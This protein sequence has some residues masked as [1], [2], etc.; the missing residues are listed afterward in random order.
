MWRN[1][2][3]YSANICWTAGKCKALLRLQGESSKEIIKLK[4]DHQWRSYPN[5]HQIMPIMKPHIR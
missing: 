4:S 5:E 2:T 1:S 3:T